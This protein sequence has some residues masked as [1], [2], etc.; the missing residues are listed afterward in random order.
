M[1]ASLLAEWTSAVT[2][3]QSAVCYTER[4]VLLTFCLTWLS[5]LGM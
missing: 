5:K 4:Y 3:M 1:A 2:Y